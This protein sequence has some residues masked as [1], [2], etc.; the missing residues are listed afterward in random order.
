MLSTP[1]KL[2]K[3]MQ[4]T[5]RPESVYTAT[6]VCNYVHCSNGLIYDDCSVFN[7]SSNQHGHC[8]DAAL[9]DICNATLIS[10]NQR[11]RYREALLCHHTALQDH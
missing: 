3:S 6:A 4:M 2:M 9:C 7:N 8:N 5:A 11:V 1:E 10:N